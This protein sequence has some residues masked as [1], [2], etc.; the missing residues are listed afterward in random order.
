MNGQDLTPEEYAQL[1]SLG[2]SNEADA[3]VMQHQMAA[4][5]RLREGN[6]PQS[7]M[8]GRVV[9]PPSWLQMLSGLARENVAH[10]ID[11]GV[12]DSMQNQ[13]MRKQQQNALVL[14]SLL[15]GQPAEQEDTGPGFMAPSPK[16]GF[17][18]GGGY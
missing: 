18:L 6:V 7:Q 4:A 17:R 12:R 9:V 3:Q 10:N 1:L 15:G 5:K 2:A 8:M 16:P 11:S 14:R 13:A